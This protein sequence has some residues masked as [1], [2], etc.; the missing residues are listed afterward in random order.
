MRK[1]AFFITGLEFGGAELAML[2]LAA[3]CEHPPLVF[4]LKSG[5]QLKSQFESKGIQVID[6]GLNVWSL[7]KNFQFIIKKLDEN[8]IGLICSWLYHADF[9]VSFLRLFRPKLK[10][11]W[12]VHNLSVGQESVKTFTRIIVYLNIILSYISPHKIIY[13]ASSAQKYHENNLRYNR[14]IG[15][16]I[17]NAVLDKNHHDISPSKNKGCPGEFVVGMAARW[18]AVKNHQLAFAAFAELQRAKPNSKLLLCGNGI[19][20]ENKSLVSMLENFKI[21]DSVELL[22]T[23][24]NMEKFYTEIDIL[25]ITSLSE[26]LPNVVVE[27]LS[28]ERPVISVPVGDI[29]EIIEN[30][31]TI[32]AY[33]ARLIAEKM[34][35]TSD[36]FAASVARVKSVKLNGELNQYSPTY[37]HSKYCEVFDAI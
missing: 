7:I 34:I 31:Y 37:V 19:T 25:L 33:D 15:T 22:G 2:K 36:N 8:D 28:H 11:V 35:F 10:L 20:S 24:T 30:L 14:R 32:V 27:S 1:V 21:K 16:V 5:G 4:S 6:V 13:C 9:F 17:K 26:A 23:L 18:D 12:T 29:P 3:A